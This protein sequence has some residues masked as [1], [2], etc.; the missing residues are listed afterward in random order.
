MCVAVASTDVGASRARAWMGLFARR[1]AAK[2]AAKAAAAMEGPS[3]G[4]HEDGAPGLGAALESFSARD[5]GRREASGDDVN[6]PVISASF[7]GDDVNSPLISASFGRRSLTETQRKSMELQQNLMSMGQS[8]STRRLV[9]SAVEELIA[10]AVQESA[11]ELCTSELMALRTMYHSIR[12]LLDDHRR[13]QEENQ[14]TSAVK[15]ITAIDNAVKIGDALMLGVHGDE[16]MEKASEM[17]D[18]ISR[19]FVEQYFETSS[20]NVNALAL[21][22]RIAKLSLDLRVRKEFAQNGSSD[23]VRYQS[24]SDIKALSRASSS[25]HG[26]FDDQFQ[27]ISW[28]GFD[29]IDFAAHCK[30]ASVGPLVKLSMQIFDHFRLFDLLPL[31]RSAF[32][33]F[34]E[35]VEAGYQSNDYHNHVHATDVTQAVA[36]F[37]ETSLL[38]QIDPVHMFSLLVSAIVHDVGHPGVNNAYLVARQTE[39][40]VRWNNVSVNENGHLFTAY[41]LLN[42]Y[43]ILDDFDVDERNLILKLLQKMVLYTDMELHAD[44]VRRVTE[45][46]EREVDVETGTLKRV[47]NWSEPWIPLAFAL[48]CADISNPA[49]PY[50]L[51][52]HW[53]SEIV[54]EFYKQGDLQRS[55]N[56]KVDG[57]MD[58][59]LAGPATTQSSQLGFIRYIVVPSIELLATFMPEVAQELMVHIND[60][61]ERYEADVAA[62]KSSP[63]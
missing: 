38:E 3:S 10:V 62:A 30:K 56:M 57:F 29:V 48:H 53:G 4:G 17:L 11:T 26:D 60:N 41:S 34:V 15:M 6:S 7:A 50:S 19:G 39:V 58:R 5:E 43:A 25:S 47:R 49:R 21:A 12:R 40:A 24:T 36:F 8:E 20:L 13:K 27:A 55:F 37:I 33:S 31:Q 46:G 1:R 51:A 28:T 14:E 45:A 32:K 2:A 54:E 9:D 35:R 42:K 44:L 16:A 61:I 52:L 63:T 18:P 59:S 23:C 22:Q